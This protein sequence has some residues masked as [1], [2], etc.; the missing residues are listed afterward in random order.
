MDLLLPQVGDGA[1]ATNYDYTKGELPELI[2]IIIASGAKLFVSAV[3]VPPRWAVEKLHAAKIPV[4]NMIGAPKHVEKA[5]N[6]GVD[7]I[8]AQ[9]GEGGGHTGEVATSILIPAVVDL[10]R[11][12][13]SPLT[14][15]PV[16]VVAAGG[17]SDG[18]GLAAALALGASAVWVGTRFVA[19][20]EGD[21]P[22]THKEA[23][24]TAG[25]HDTIR[26]LVFSGRPMRIKKNA[27]AAMR[28]GPSGQRTAPASPLTLHAHPAPPAR[29]CR[30]V[31]NWEEE[32]GEEM[33]SALKKGK[34]PYTVDEERG[35]WTPEQRASATPWL[36]GQVAGAVHEIK[37]AA[38]IVNE[39]VRDAVAI[40]RGN[41]GLVAKL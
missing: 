21:A 19:S 26:T 34:L 27:Y 31:M 13:R 8:C 22:D 24:V 15:G 37:P 14:G 10:C 18:R 11:G 25:Y 38:E 16:L 3:G 30:Y 39:M 2:D 33:R 4:M 5:L 7:I 20:V 6:A 1:R 41:A 9:G 32:R 36:M 12:R 23:V 35:G 29:S 40:V 17:I 28:L